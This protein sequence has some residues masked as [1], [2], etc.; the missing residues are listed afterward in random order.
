MACR[1]SIGVLLVAA[2]LIPG[3]DTV[4][5]QQYRISGIHANSAD[6]D[7]LKSVVMGVANRY[8]LKDATETSRVPNTLIFVTEPDVKNFRTD[9]GVRLNG[10]DALVDVSAGIGPRVEKFERV[11]DAL[12]PALAAEFGARC[13]AVSPEKRAP[14]P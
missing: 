5:W 3:C 11:R 2:A 6:A 13:I 1:S 12:G 7:R 8:A 14:V 9:I 4:N 10:D